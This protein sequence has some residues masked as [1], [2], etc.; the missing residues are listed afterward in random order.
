[1]NVRAMRMSA[2]SDED[3]ANVTFV[4]VGNTLACP[5]AR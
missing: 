2:G 1:M 4:P 3:M 5:R